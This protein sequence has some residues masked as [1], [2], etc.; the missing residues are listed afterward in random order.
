MVGVFL[1]GL[2]LVFGLS[3]FFASLIQDLDRQGAN[4][5]ARLFIG[6]EIVRDIQ[7]IEKDFYRLS[8]TQGERA[9]ELLSTATLK[10]VDNLESDL[11][12]LKYGGTVRNIIQLNIDGVEEMV[13]EATYHPT[14][15]SSPYVMEAIELAPHLTLLRDHLGILKALAG[16]IEAEP[17]GSAEKIRQ[18]RELRLFLKTV[19]SF[20]HRLN[21]NANRLFYNSTRKIEEIEGDLRTQRG[22]YQTLEIALMVLVI[23]ILALFGFLVVRQDKEANTRLNHA[24]EALHSARDQAEHM[25]TH[26]ALCGL[27]NRFFLESR[28][29]QFIAK[30]RRNGGIGAVAFLDLDGF[31]AINDHY[32]HDYGDILLQ[33]VSR[34]LSDNV[35]ASDTVARLGGDEFILLIEDLRDPGEAVMVVEKIFGCLRRTYQL[36][37]HQVYVTGSCG[38]ALF[39]Q[40]GQDPQTLIKHADTAMYRAKEGGRNRYCLYDAGMT[41]AVVMQLNTRNDLR[42]AIVDDQLRVYFQPLVESTHGR[43]VGT[44]ALVRWQHPVRGLLSPDDFIEVAEQSGLIVGLGTWVLDHAILASLAWL[45]LAMPGFRLHVNVSA[46]QLKQADFFDQVEAILA[47]HQFPAA[48]LVLEMTESVLIDDKV[49]SGNLFER[50]RK[51]GVGIALDDFGTGYSSLAYLKTLPVDHI[52]IDKSFVQ[53][54]PTD[55]D[56]CALVEATFIFSR[57]LGIEVIA[58]GVETDIQRNWLRDQG[59][60]YMQGYYFGRP[61]PAEDFQAR[62]VDENR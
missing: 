43:I 17:D 44:E 42:L 1:A 61:M 23:A 48:N 13:R 15:D 39:P 47:R 12:A 52:K 30:T 11:E 35:R 56:D 18:Q 57:R 5:R 41:E 2:L 20:F 19:P 24:W 31:K 16:R 34:C 8:A 22:Y 50:L 21:E 55:P 36:N 49:R 40:D 54:V 38:V 60:R 29:N 7:L 10:R 32:G 37:Q 14:K 58:E 51:L 3:L 28:L 26:D 33:Q 25:A 9:R 27:P 62:L 4:E 6:E 53:D 59:C 46:H 45:P